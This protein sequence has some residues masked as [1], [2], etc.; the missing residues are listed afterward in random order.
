MMGALRHPSITSASGNTDGRVTPSIQTKELGLP[1]GA[2]S[3][4]VF[5]VKS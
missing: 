3:V 5:D 4:G 1:A 2:F